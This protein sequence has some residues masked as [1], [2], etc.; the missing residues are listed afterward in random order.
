MKKPHHKSELYFLLVLLCSIFVLTFFIFKP[1]LF[2]LTLAIVFATIFDPLHDRVLKLTRGHKGLGALLATIC[3]LILAIVPL[4]FLGIQIFQEA[5]ALYTSLASGNGAADLSRNANITIH[6]LTRLSPVPIEFST[7]INQYIQEALNFLLQ[8]LG[9]LFANVAKGSISLFIFLI[10]LYY[11]FK[12]GHKLRRALVNISPLQDVH[13]ETI[14][15]KLA[16][17]INSVIRGNLAV[18]IIQGSATAIGFLLFTVPN[19]VLWGSAAAIAALV[20]SL[21][22]SLVLLPAIAYLYISGN[23]TLAIGLTVW[24]ILAVGLIDNFLGPMLVGRGTR[25]HPFLV[26]LSILGGIGFFGPI[27]F[28]LGPL[29]LSLLFALLEIYFSISKEHKKTP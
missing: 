26:L 20:P 17:A 27:G 19:P 2:A 24:G 11:L 8:R 23:I 12:D 10:A 3:V 4:T 28:L 18:A 21:G 22:T 13:D 29:T 7:D 6:K 25:L 5:T 9:P 1:F 15:H 14:F 16:L